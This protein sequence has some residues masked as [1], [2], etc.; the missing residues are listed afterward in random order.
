M[1]K[2]TIVF[3]VV[4][5][6]IG[7]YSYSQDITSIEAWQTASSWV[8]SISN[9][10][11]YTVS[12][13]EP[14]FGTNN[15][16]SYH[17]T[18]FPKG[19]I[20][21]SANK[22]IHPVI[23]YSFENTLILNQPENQIIEN[24]L[25]SLI[26]TDI[27]FRLD[28]I[29]KQPDE[30][31]ASNI[32]TWD[33]YLNSSYDQ[34]DFEQWPPQGSTST[35][36]WVESEWS[37]S[38]P[39]NDFCPMDLVSGQRSIAGCPSVAISMIIDYT[40]TINGTRFNDDDDYYHNYG[41]NSYWIDDDY[42]MFDFLSFDSL[43]S[44]Y[45]LIENQ[46]ANNNQLTDDQ[47]SALVFGCGV[48]AR[49]V[50]AS[51]GSGTFGVDQAYDSFIR[52]GFDDA[53]LV[54]DAD[55]SFYLH[56]Q[57]NIKDAMPILLAL[58]IDNGPGGHNVIADGYNTD[59]FYHL[60]FGWG[61]PYNSWYH[62][63]EGIPYNL[64]I[65]EGAIMDI[66]TKQVSVDEEDR[67]VDFSILAYPNPT[68]GNTNISINLNTISDIEISCF[69]ISGRLIQVIANG[70]FTSGTHTFSTNLLE[71]GN[72]IIK[73]TKDNETLYTSLIVN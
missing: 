44:Y 61:G 46:Y 25:L 17:I 30:I 55:S 18:L 67:I 32:A 36:G 7:V 27:E 54:Y 49:Q 31:R 47:K 38:S 5:H 22:Q 60:N 51:G 33:Q 62:I 63:P 66:G 39:Y 10:N 35:G 29:S 45:E 53:Q 23:A 4:F 21:L 14:V 2:S 15:I 41:G 52:F 8:K 65:V 11:E 19:S 71:K 56:I 50:Y 24:P 42:K 12:N 64:T 28:N 16:I 34:L 70:K 57:N 48:A 26:R 59:D 20:V 3:I 13:I 69:D 6:V 40:N 68:L 58:L 1:K 73:A 9:E 37:Q 72:Y 43:N